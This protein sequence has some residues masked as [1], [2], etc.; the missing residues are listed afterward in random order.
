VSILFVTGTDTGAGKTLVGAAITAGLRARGVRLGVAKPC[1][2]GC[3]PVDPRDPDGTLFPEDA[4]TLA[5]AAGNDEP[6]E[7][8]C[9]YR[10]PDPLAPSLAA[11]RVGASID[12]PRLVETLTAR[13]RTLDLLLVEGAGGLLVPLT[14]DASFA[15]LAQHLGARVLLVVGSRLGAINHALLS[16]AVLRARG[17]PTAGY[18]VNRLAPDDDL[19]VA[20]N[21]ALL[22]SLTDAPL[23]GELPH[24]PDAST[25]LA[26]LRAGGPTA[27]SARA[28]LAGLA[29]EHLALSAARSA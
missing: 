16:L 26:T 19:A 18:V 3:N 22:R 10:F 15:D 24:L 28:R 1:E 4:A 7:T 13:A 27:A 12:V 9:P 5:S 23:L 29:E 17:I 14:R 21:T 11:E 20:T 2:T 25:M 8:V 6:I